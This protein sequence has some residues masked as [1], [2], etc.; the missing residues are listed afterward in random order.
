VSELV[1]ALEE[2]LLSR[3]AERTK[4][5]GPMVVVLGAHGRG[6]SRLA[7][8]MLGVGP[9]S[10]CNEATAYCGS[11]W[12][13]ESRRL[14]P[15]SFICRAPE[16]LDPRLVV[17][18]CAALDS[19]AGEEH[20]KVY[21]E[22]ADI[23][24]FCV[25]VTQPQGKAEVDFVMRHLQ[26]KAPVLVI[27]MSDLADDEDFS[28]ALEAILAVYGSVAW[29]AITVSDYAG[30]LAPRSNL[31][32]FDRWWA[33]QGIFAIFTARSARIER[34]AELWGK[35]SSIRLD[36]RKATLD[37]EIETLRRQAMA[38]DLQRR[39]LDAKN[40]IDGSL[41]SLPRS[42]ARAY[43]ERFADLRRQ[44]HVRLE[45]FRSANESGRQESPEEL[46][47]ALSRILED[48]EASAR[49]W[50]REALY[51]NMQCL[52]RQAEAYVK[53]VQ[54][55]CPDVRSTRSLPGDQAEE[56]VPGPFTLTTTAL[57]DGEMARPLVASGTATLGGVLLVK[58][59]IFTA[60][61]AI[62]W[63]VAL[64]VGI[65]SGS[66]TYTM[67]K[68][69]IDRS[70]TAE[71]HRAVSL[72][73]SIL[74]GELNRRLEED[75]RHFC[76]GIETELAPFARALGTLVLEQSADSEQFAR[77]TQER[78]RTEEEIRSVNERVR[79]LMGGRP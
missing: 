26:D 33:E 17:V 11:A 10:P 23:A 53:A 37:G 15:G 44:V 34:D 6:K 50:V 8:R 14:P 54:H 68:K 39:A 1:S 32:S 73:M 58:A 7:A 38:S 12:V 16:A 76:F 19:Q 5:P 22:S 3:I 18:D 21:A 42:A 36:A 60:L 2:D 72:R 43:S 52:R 57:S 31:M 41:A 64:A 20:A 49:H 71:V 67:L 79:E 13:S 48:W 59:A 74:E 9:A 25:Q 51:E 55:L 70:A 27:T 66:T 75:W 61:G 24:I 56:T 77:L 4:C 69:G 45:E 78:E 47:T 62:A 63:P 29:A 28:H 40:S 30:S 65:A 46:Q 35:Q